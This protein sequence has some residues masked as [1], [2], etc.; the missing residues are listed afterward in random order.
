MYFFTKLLL[1]VTF[2]TCKAPWYCCVS[3]QPLE[4]T[5]HNVR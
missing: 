4:R 5:K 1:Y 2:E 3:W